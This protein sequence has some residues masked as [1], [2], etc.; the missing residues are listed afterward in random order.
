MSAMGT[1]KVIYDKSVVRK[2]SE[3]DTL[4]C[5]LYPRTLFYAS[6]YQWL[7]RFGAQDSKTQV[8]VTRRYKIRLQKTNSRDKIS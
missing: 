5:P 8:G 3:F 7:G 1:G 4:N 2:E 6:N